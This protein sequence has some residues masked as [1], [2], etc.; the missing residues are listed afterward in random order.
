MPLAGFEP[1]TLE[2]CSN[3]SD[4]TAFSVCFDMC[5]RE[6]QMKKLTIFYVFRNI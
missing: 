6:M 4:H 3:A 1:A 2:T 5:V